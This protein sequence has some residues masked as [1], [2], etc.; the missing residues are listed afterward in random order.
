L[1]AALLDSRITG[2]SAGT[3]SAVF[4][5]IDHGTSTYTPNE[6]CWAADVDLAA[7]AVYRDGSTFGATLITPRHFLMADHAS[8]VPASLRFRRT[9][10]TLVNV[11]VTGLQRVGTTDIVSGGSPKMS[12]ASRP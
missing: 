2:K 1:V 6:T 9:D 3:D 12:P 10:G 5:S 11:A 4:D 8:G 7:V